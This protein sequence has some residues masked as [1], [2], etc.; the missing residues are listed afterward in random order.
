MGDQKAVVVT[1]EA[2]EGSP[3]FEMEVLEKYLQDGWRVVSATPM[4]GAGPGQ[5]EARLVFA[6]LVVL[7]RGATSYR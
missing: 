5:N 4:G 6:A 1:F 7:Q 2:T 3:Y